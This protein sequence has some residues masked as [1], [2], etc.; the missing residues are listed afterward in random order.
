MLK[1]LN[2]SNLQ[3]SMLYLSE[4]NDEY[5]TIGEIGFNEEMESVFSD[6]E[7]IWADVKSIQFSKSKED[8]VIHLNN[9]E[10]FHVPVDTSGLVS[11]FKNMPAGLNTPEQTVF[12]EQIYSELSSCKVCGNVAVWQN[13]CNVCHTDQDDVVNS[14][15]KVEL[16]NIKEEQ[17]QLFATYEEDEPIDWEFHIDPNFK[18]DPNWKLLVNEAEI[19]EF[20]RENTW[21][22]E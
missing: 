4:I 5:F 21:E 10:H 13:Q 11:L 22:E 19:I 6:R 3:I 15:P 14:D 20:S 9:G 12:I 1:S 7:V 17:L 16:E 2:F 8:V 18:R